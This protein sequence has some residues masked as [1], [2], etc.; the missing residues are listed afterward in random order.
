MR[1]LAM[2]GVLRNG[3]LTPPRSLTPSLLPYP[4]LGAYS[5]NHHGNQWEAGRDW[6]RRQGEGSV[7]SDWVT[8]SWVHNFCACM[9]ILPLSRGLAP[10]VWSA[11]TDLFLGGLILIWLCLYF[12]TIKVW[13]LIP[14]TYAG[15]Y[16]LGPCSNWVWVLLPVVS[17][18]W[19]PP[20]LP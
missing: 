1:F 9:Q 15:R 8:L 3:D 11:S 17:V 18:P 5:M 4:F 16:Y 6:W 7:C 13:S 20:G 14:G 10:Q 2:A 19:L 12:N